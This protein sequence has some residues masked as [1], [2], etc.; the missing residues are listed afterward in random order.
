MPDILNRKEALNPSLR[1][2]I[3][4]GGPLGEMMQ[5]PLVHEVMYT[6]QLNALLNE[7]F[8]QK[9]SALNHALETKNWSSVIWLHERPYRIDVLLNNQKQMTHKQYWESAGNIWTD[10]ENIWQNYDNWRTIWESPRP[11]KKYAMDLTERKQLALMP[12][13]ITVYRGV[14]GRGISKNKKPGMSWTTDKEKAEWFAN[15]WQQFPRKVIEG[16][17]N[18]SDVHAYFA[19][20]GESEIVATRIA[21]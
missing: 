21:K 10:S 4:S 3:V 13:I 6:P 12:Q 19:G 9:T 18:K 8:K 15:R 20:R 5:H 2:Y 14:N 17:V 11:Q 1:P 7:R 16:T